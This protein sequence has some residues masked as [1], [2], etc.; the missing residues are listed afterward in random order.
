[1]A[2]TFDKQKA[3]CLAGVDLS[4]KGSIDAPIT[5]IVALINANDDFFTTSSCSGRII[6][7]DNDSG[8]SVKKKGCRW[9]LTS[10]EAVSVDEVTESLKTVQCNA[11]F[12][13]EPFIMHIQCRGLEHAQAMLNA[14]VSSGN[15]NSGISVGNKGKFITAIRSTQSLEVPLTSKGRLLVDEKYLQF[16]VSLANSKMVDNLDRIQRFFTNL[17]STLENTSKSKVEEEKAP[18][19]KATHDYSKPRRKD[20]DQQTD[21]YEDLVC[22]AMFDCELDT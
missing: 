18:K 4:R 19:T 20:A 6:I 22:C 11:V 12:K 7:V 15:R 5:D 8:G 3:S 9:V 16:L 2:S 10:H 13:F 17:K 14:A 1:M 21:N